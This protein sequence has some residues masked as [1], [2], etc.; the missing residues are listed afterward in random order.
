LPLIEITTDSSFV[1]IFVNLFSKF[2][3]LIKEQKE[4]KVVMILN[5]GELGGNKEIFNKY[6]E[7]LIDYE[8]SYDPKPSESLEILQDKLTAFKECELLP[9]YLTEHKIN[10]IRVIR[11]IINALNDFS[12]IQTDIQGAPE[13]ETEIMSRCLNICPYRLIINFRFNNFF[14]RLFINK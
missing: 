11:R 12:F 13:V 3:V 7:K 2:A 1:R 5:E 8:F 9:K 10:N 4:C 6:K 14:K